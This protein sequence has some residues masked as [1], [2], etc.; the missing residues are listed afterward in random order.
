MNLKEFKKKYDIIS[1]KYN[2]NKS[3]GIWFKES[4]ESIVILDLQKSNYGN[5]FDLNIKIII[6]GFLNDFHEVSKDL[7]KKNTGDIFIRQPN[8]YKDIFDLSNSLNDLKRLEK[9]EDFF[10]DF[11]VPFT[12]KGLTKRGILKLAADGVIY[13]LPAVK[14]ELIKN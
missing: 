1:I 3:L 7:L 13:L 14:D 9:L 10:K 6:K 5:H 12:E 4:S 2:F 8:L 11:I